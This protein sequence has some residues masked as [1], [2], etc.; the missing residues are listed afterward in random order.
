MIIQVVDFLSKFASYPSK[1]PEQVNPG[2]I[3]G[4]RID[5]MDRSRPI[6]IGGDQHSPCG[7]VARVGLGW[8]VK[9]AL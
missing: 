9:N 5:P 8:N 2:R 4:I 1:I 6:P 3:P 7:G